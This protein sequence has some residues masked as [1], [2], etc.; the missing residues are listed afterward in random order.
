MEEILRHEKSAA[1]VLCQLKA[2]HGAQASNI[3]MTKGV[4][5]IVAALGKVDDDD[6]SR[7]DYE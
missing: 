2:R 1:G 4:L 7:Y 6:L 5:G 3:P